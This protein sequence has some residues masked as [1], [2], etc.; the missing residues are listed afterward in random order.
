MIGT[1]DHHPKVTRFEPAPL[2][3]RWAL[4]ASM[5]LIIGVLLW[6]R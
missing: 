5:A 4:V 3:A 6:I 1:E 2:W